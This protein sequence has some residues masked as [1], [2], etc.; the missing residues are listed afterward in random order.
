MIHVRVPWN[1]AAAALLLV[2]PGV[3]VT[4]VT[5]PGVVRGGFVFTESPAP[6]VHASTLVETKEGILAAW[7]GGSREGASDVGIWMSREASGAWTPPLLVATGEQPDGT[8]YPCWNPVLFQPRDGPLMLFYKVGPSPA[9]W[10]GMMRTSSDEG[11]SWS[12]ARRLPEGVLGP[13]KNKPVQL[14]DGT[15]LSG[16]STES[17]DQPS[18]WR[19]H[20]E[21]STD[22][23]RT[24]SISRPPDT[25]EAI[26]AI[27]PSLL[28]HPRGRL[29][30]VGR[31]RSE[32]VFETWSDDNGR[33]WRPL[34]LGVL[35]NPNSGVDALTLR[36][37]RQLIVYNHTSR[38]RTPLNVAIS[39]DGQQW[40]AAVVLESEPGEFSY[41]AVIQS[42]DGLVHIT[43]TWNRTR[44]KHVVLDP[45]A[46]R[47]TPL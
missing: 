44:I 29:E 5:T 17:T 24:W 12:A 39:D 22:G 35:P 6:S 16:S 38:G 43:Y 40:R 4:Q 32:R 15:I 33:S 42:R 30:A 25:A 41:P 8:R 1:V 31:T 26:D 11:R 21:L 14:A 45:A 46:L 37:G 36:D 10:W 27:Q 3:A 9:T 7:F 23:G 2:A 18:R 19:V 47:L 13:I 28:V 20:F 34:A